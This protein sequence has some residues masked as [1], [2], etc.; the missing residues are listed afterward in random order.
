[1]PRRQLHDSGGLNRTFQVNVQ[2][3]LWQGSEK[4]FDGGRIQRVG[5]YWGGSCGRPALTHAVIQYEPTSVAASESWR[6]RTAPA[7]L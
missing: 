4:L 5:A 3:G 2:L 6:I 1:M 7:R